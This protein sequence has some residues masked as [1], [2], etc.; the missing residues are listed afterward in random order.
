MNTLRAKAR[1]WFLARHG[2]LARLPSMAKHSPNRSV[3]H[4]PFGLSF[5]GCS[6]ET[7][8]GGAIS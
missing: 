2:F 5:L 4:Y 3:S 1:S 6:F 7:T 8:V